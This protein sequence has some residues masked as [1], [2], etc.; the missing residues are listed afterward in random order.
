MGLLSRPRGFPRVPMAM[1]RGC[2][3]RR[4]EADALVGVLGRGLGAAG[5]H[6]RDAVVVPSVREIRYVSGRARARTVYRQLGT[7]V[8][9]VVGTTQVEITEHRRLLRQVHEHRRVRPPWR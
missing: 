7:V 5:R 9:G 6:R 1:G 4:A 2:R 3:W 8:A